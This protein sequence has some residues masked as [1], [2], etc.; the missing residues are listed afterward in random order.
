MTG[1]CFRMLGVHAALGR[2]ISEEDDKPGGGPEGYA[3]VLGYDYWHSHL[4]GDPNVLGRVLDFEGKKGVVVGV[5]EPGFE[6]VTVGDRPWIYMPSEIGD[7]DDRH[8]FGSWNR[9]LLG[10]L[11]D[12]ATA[13]QLLAQS[14]PVYTAA[15]KAEKEFHY[16]TQDS[17]GEFVQASGAHL[18]VL[19]GRTGISYLRSEYAQALYLIEGL[20]GL[21]LLVACAYLGQPGRHAGAGAAARAC[22]TRGAG[23]KPRS[24]HGAALLGEPAAGAGGNGAGASVCLGHEPRAGAPD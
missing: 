23:R 11:K 15:L 24:S 8:G 14:D 5:M 7:R 12:G 20:V 13:T 16:Y 17:S 21:S 22:R 19:P 3:M 10:R 6:S 18:L 1:G 4:G 2:L 9:V